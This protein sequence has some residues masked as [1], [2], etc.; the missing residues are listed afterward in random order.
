MRVEG[1]LDL[2]HS[3]DVCEV[4]SGDSERRLPVCPGLKKQMNTHTEGIIVDGGI[5]SGDIIAVAGSHNLSGDGAPVEPS[6]P[7]YAA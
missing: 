6:P 2:G 3:L 7:A 4:E 5:D 1:L